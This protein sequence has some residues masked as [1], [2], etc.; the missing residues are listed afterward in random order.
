MSANENRADLPEATLLLATAALSPRSGSGS[1]PTVTIDP[2]SFLPADKAAV[3]G[4]APG[5][6]V[7]TQGKITVTG[8]VGGQSENAGLS[9]TVQIGDQD[10]THTATL[11][12][13]NS[14]TNGNG[15]WNW[16]YT[17]STPVG[18]ELDIIVTA[19]LTY[20]QPE[21][22]GETHRLSWNYETQTDSLSH[23]AIV[24]TAPVV[25]S[26][27][28]GQVFQGTA[29]GSLVTA[30]GRIVPVNSAQV[31]WVLE[32]GST[33][34]VASDAQG[35]WSA[36]IP[37]PLGPHT[38]TFTALVGAN[39]APSPPI[40]LNI[41][42][43]L[44]ADIVDAEPSSYLRALLEFATQPF[45]PDGTAR[46]VTGSGSLTPQAIDDAFFQSTTDVLDPTYIAKANETV[47][48]S[49]I[50]CEVLRRFLVRYPPNA[51]QQQ[52]LAN[53]ELAYLQTGYLSMLTQI[54]TSYDE[55]RLAR[56]YNR[57]NPDD[58]KKLQA[59]ADRLGIDI[60]ERNTL[61]GPLDHLDQLCFNLNP[62]SDPV[63]PSVTESAL[64]QLFGLVD[65]TRDGTVNL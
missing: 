55:L 10:V 29:T 45:H 17:G 42:V 23:H 11:T 16:T 39:R 40:T 56:T 46:V 25:T 50:C 20:R 6:S 38:I 62:A 8:C 22:D 3:V 47:R 35:S 30:T 58:H 36:P 52:A 14:G 19:T 65:T 41:Q 24:A 7:T 12:V 64:E 2:N 21:Y 44:R 53:A 27:A 43:A 57:Q 34:T 18:G 61:L 1:T 31:Q 4:P 15:T 51:D 49:R 54:G 9:V 33:A 63:L 5:V 26:P 48:Q 37:V 13:A 28:E 60:G 59:I 32:N